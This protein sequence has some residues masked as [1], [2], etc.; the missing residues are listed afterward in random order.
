MFLLKVT[1]NINAVTRPLIFPIALAFGDPHYRT[2]DGIFYTFNGYGEFWL[3]QVVDATIHGEKINFKLQA[4]F[5]QP[6][7]QSCEQ[8]I[9]PF[10]TI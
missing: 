10:V 4:R 8:A 9:F 3:M 5:E 2:F 7:N 1:E 6:A